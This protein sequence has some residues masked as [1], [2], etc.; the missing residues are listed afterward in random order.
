VEHAVLVDK[1]VTNATFDHVVEIGLG[2]N[3][4]CARKDNGDVYCWGWGLAGLLGDGLQD[5]NV[6][7]PQKVPLV[8]AYKA[9]AIGGYVSCGID[10]NGQARCW[11]SNGTSDLGHAAGTDGDVAV[12]G[13]YGNVTPQLVQGLGPAKALAVGGF[14]ACGVDSQGVGCWGEDWDSDNATGAGELGDLGEAGTSSGVAVRLAIP[15]AAHVAAGHSFACAWADAP[16][17]GADA[18]APEG[19]G[20]ASASCWGNNEWGELGL[21]NFTSPLAPTSV[22]VGAPGVAEMGGSWGTLFVLGTDHSVWTSGYNGNGELATG[23]VGS[24]SACTL[25][26]TPNCR[27]SMAQA[28]DP[29]MT[30]TLQARHLAVGYRHACVIGVDDAVYCWGANENGQLGNGASSASPRPLPVKVVGLP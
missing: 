3:H 27:P 5:H 29:T 19:G 26:S 9:I 25:D 24:E 7:A 11:G 14:F 22:S 28:L 20:P 8:S 15:N 18:S 1:D 13:G 21:G 30:T 23:A 2:A 12:G 10:K 4:T 17:G 6:A 16:D